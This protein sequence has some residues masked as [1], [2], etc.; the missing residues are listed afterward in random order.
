MI[1]RV[2]RV[3]SIQVT[4]E[5]FI[6]EDGKMAKCE[7]DTHA[8]TS[9]AGCN[10]RMCEFDG[11]TCEV[12]PFS[13]DYESTK[14]VPIVSAATAWT[15]E[16]TG[17]T[18][19]LYFHQMFWYGDKLAN[20]LI[21]PNQIRRIGRPVCD[22]VTDKTRQFGINIDDK[23]VIPFTMTGTTIYFET[24]V[25]SNWELENC[26]ILVMTDES[27]WDP[28]TV[29]ITTVTSEPILR[30]TRKSHRE[31]VRRADTVDELQCISNVYD[32][33]RP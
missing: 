11:V 12:V 16:H 1:G 31:P 8:D 4:D 30:P 25:P 26:H 21:N 17:E 18:V 13:E 32:E 9:I 15:N 3:N 27:T 20:I 28:N 5:R 7:L 24:R 29:S 2:T 6:T 23:F 14:D 33:R 19:V 22:D 10:F